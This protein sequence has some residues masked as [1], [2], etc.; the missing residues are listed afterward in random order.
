Q[1]CVKG[2]LYME[3]TWFNQYSAGVPHTI[4]PDQYDSL[5]AFFNQKCEQ[6]EDRPAFRHMNCILTYEQLHH[7]AR[8]FAGFC[9]QTLK[10]Q[11]G[12]RLAIM[13]PNI[14]QYP[15]VMFGAW[16]AGLIV[17]NVNPL[18]TPRELREQL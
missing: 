16:M 8:A 17:V 1:R 7:Q 11:R 9:Q 2:N 12:D 15:V 10:L 18:Y 4:E 14:L 5:V 6:F 3:K 13:L